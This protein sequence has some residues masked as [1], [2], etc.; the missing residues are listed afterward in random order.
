M[1][2]FELNLVVRRRTSSLISVETTHVHKHKE[3]PRI[4]SRCEFRYHHKLCS[5]SVCFKTVF[6]II[7]PTDSIYKK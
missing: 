5:I 6:I 3:V 4:K 7:K 1:T 2:T